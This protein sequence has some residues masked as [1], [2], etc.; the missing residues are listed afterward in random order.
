MEKKSLLR[1]IAVSPVLAAAATVQAASRTENPN[2]V[3]IL[4][5]DLGYGDLSCLNPDGKIPTRHID[6]LARQGVVLQMHIPVRPSVRR[7]VTAC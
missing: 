7:R 3:L 6:S 5:D 1:L 2:V 4:A